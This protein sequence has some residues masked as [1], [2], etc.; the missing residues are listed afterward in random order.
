[1]PSCMYI[2]TILVYTFST[3]IKDD[4]NTKFYLI[5]IIDCDEEYET[6]HVWY[7]KLSR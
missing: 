7:E 6:I 1:M 5:F 4:L 2:I 3:D